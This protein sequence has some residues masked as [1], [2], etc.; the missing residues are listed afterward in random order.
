MGKKKPKKGKIA[1]GTTPEKTRSENVDTR[2]EEREE[3]P[4]FGGLPARDLKKNLGCG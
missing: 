3:R 1:S 2:A 4:D